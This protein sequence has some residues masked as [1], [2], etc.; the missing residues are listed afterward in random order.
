MLKVYAAIGR[1]KKGLRNAHADSELL[2]EQTDKAL[3]EL[4]KDA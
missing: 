4:S 2:T 1:L 3:A